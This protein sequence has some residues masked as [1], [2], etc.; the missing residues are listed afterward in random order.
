[1]TIVAV[2]GIANRLKGLAPDEAAA[3]LS[4]RWRSKLQQ[5]FAS[6]GLDDHPLPALHAA[7]YAHHTTTTG[8]ERQSDG[9]DLDS[10]DEPERD[11]VVAWA[12]SSGS[13]ALHEQQGL[14]TAPL[15]QLLSWVARR[16][17]V[18]LG[19]VTRFAVRLAGEVRRYLHVPQVR[20]AARSIVAEAIRRARP[21]VVLAH[22]LGS[23]VT[24]EALHAHPE[25]EVE[26]FVTLGSPL[27]LAGGVFDHLLP[28]P[29]TDR[30]SRPAGVGY[31]AN[32]ADT[33]DLVAIPPRLGD[34]FPVDQHADTHMGLIDFH[35]FGTYLAS[36]LTAATIA[37]F[38][39]P[40]P[41]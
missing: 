34:R 21:R 38:I 25:L 41:R 28:A 10:L 35:T 39:R 23:V 17:G 14:A 16:R 9:P 8:A 30:G 5:G 22:S 32:L 19:T 27:G 7:Y 15:R 18:P 11:F 6:A 20:D 40:E 33:G 13:P 36:P 2:H 37:P 31:W 29:V 26:C 12:L 24:Y 3:E 4:K 1:M